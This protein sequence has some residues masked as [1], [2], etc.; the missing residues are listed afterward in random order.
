MLFRLNLS[1]YPSKRRP[2]FTARQS[3]SLRAGISS[4]APLA[5]DSSDF[6]NRG[7]LTIV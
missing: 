5:K 3:P 7:F 4:P 2:Y 6:A 1:R